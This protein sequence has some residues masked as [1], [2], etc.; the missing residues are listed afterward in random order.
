MQ[1]K[2]LIPTPL[3]AAAA[4]RQVEIIAAVTPKRFR[5]LSLAGFVVRVAWLWWRTSLLLL[6]TG[7][8]NPREGAS[9][10]R[11]FIEEMGGLWVKVGQVVAMRRDVFRPE[12]CDE[13]SRLQD[14][15]RGF[16]FELVRRTIEEELGIPLEHIFSE[17]NPLPIAAASIGQ[18]HEARL[19]HHDDVRVAVKVQRPFV[20]Q[21]FAHDLRYLRT[22]AGWLTRL[23]V[24]PQ[25]RWIDM[26]WELEKTLTEELDYRMEAS[27]IIRSWKKLRRH[28]VYVP[29]VFQSYCSRR[30]LVMEFV[31]GVF[32]SDYIKVANEDPARLHR[33]LEEN[34]I[35]PAKVGE[36]LVMTHLRQVFEDNLFHADLHPGNIL[37]QRNNRV[38][39]I[40]FGAI[41]SF[42]MTRLQR[43]RQIF[44]S[45]ALGDYTKATDLF[46]LIVPPLPG[47]QDIAA[48][49]SEM[50]RG[51]RSWESRT[52]IKAIPY[53]EKSVAGL[54]AGFFNVF[55][56]Y[57]I[58]FS[59]DFLTLNRSDLTLDASLFFLLPDANFGK[60][61]RKY[62][63]QA[64][65]RA[66][67]RF[68]KPG[69]LVKKIGDLAAVAQLPGTLAENLSLEG[70]WLRK[71]ALSFEGKLSKLAALAKSGLSMVSMAILLLGAVVVGGFI[72]RLQGYPEALETW[73][74]R[75]ILD[76]I[77]HFQTDRL[78]LLA[79]GAVYA[80]QQLSKLRDYVQ[81]RDYGNTG[82]S[83]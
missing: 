2:H 37:L 69:A 40:D 42:E 22:I 27:A 59:W 47:N 63:R 7:R 38:A 75:R 56:R 66:R 36:R 13:L 32:M 24:G 20:A 76:T 71:R 64:S 1:K 23:G 6:F 72:R 70:E 16:P 8:A 79:V 34:K 18:T 33:W 83:R 4:K 50:V 29:E 14:Q 46:L 65:E 58:S 60:L 52:A 82:H 57:K 73:W 12:T 35:V 11:M 10:I 43:Y 53:H 25:V 68:V 15:A 80:L 48:F 54:F 17:F 9:R 26:V 61:L 19:R 41:G 67:A 78:I 21:S 49:K 3:V 51:I 30:V 45:I 28:K 44:T 55:A 74:V 39:F 77:Q 62:V 81:Q 5:V 31:E